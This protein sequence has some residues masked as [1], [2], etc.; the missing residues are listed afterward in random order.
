M[1][2]FLEVPV[3]GFNYNTVRDKSNEA[4]STEVAER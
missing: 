2:L 4:T 1:H 3:P